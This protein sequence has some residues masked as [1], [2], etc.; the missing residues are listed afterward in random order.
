MKVSE[1]LRVTR[2]KMQ[3]K[4]GFALVVTIVVS[5]ITMSVPNLI[6]PSLGTMEFWANTLWLILVSSPIAM[7]ALWLFLDLYDGVEVELRHVFDIFRD[8]SRVVTAVFWKRLFIVGWMLLFLIPG[9]FAMIRYSQM[10]FLMKDDPMMTGQDAIRKSKEMMRGNKARYFIL[11][12]SIFWPALLGLALG[13]FMM[14]DA[15]A[16]G[17]L[18]AG[19]VFVDQT[20]ASRAQLVSLVST[21][22]FHLLN[23]YARP[24]FAV[25]YRDLKSLEKEDDGWGMEGF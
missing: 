6:T 11:Y 25:F 16:T 14:M 21:A 2:E 4:W 13:V 12:L 24:A 17:Y 20:R 5:A 15:F 3:G 22:A 10:E 18:F 9:I 7:G 1:I 8:Y 19:S 23:A